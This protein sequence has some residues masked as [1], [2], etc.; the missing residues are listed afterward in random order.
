MTMMMHGHVT[1]GQGWEVHRASQPLV[2]RGAV[3]RDLAAGTVDG[4]VRGSSSSRHLNQRGDAAV[5]PT[6]RRRRVHTEPTMVGRSVSGSRRSRPPSHHSGPHRKVRGAGRVTG[7]DR[8]RGPRRGSASGRRPSPPHG[9]D[10]RRRAG[11]SSSLARSMVSVV[12]TNA[13]G[14]VG[15]V[16]DGSKT[17]WPQSWR[18]RDAGRRDVEPARPRQL[19]AGDRA[20]DGDPAS[21]PLAHPLGPDGTAT[22]SSAMPRAPVRSR[23]T[24]WE[25]LHA[26]GAV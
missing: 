23:A 1:V 15:V 8:R 6:C 4:A 11:R 22:S 14:Q 9:A 17:G 20:G 18:R 12:A 24:V 13:P 25:A 21:R 7:G 5:E 10:S 16:L 3:D 26:A 19:L 2:D